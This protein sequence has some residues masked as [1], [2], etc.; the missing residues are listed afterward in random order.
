[1]FE[2]RV[3]KRYGF[4]NE[5]FTYFVEESCHVLSLGNKEKYQYTVRREPILKTL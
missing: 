2:D 3:G 5:R 4:K 1:M